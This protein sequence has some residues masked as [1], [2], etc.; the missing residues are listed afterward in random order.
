MAC[1]KIDFIYILDQ[2]R[3]FASV[4]LTNYKRY[5]VKF[6]YEIIHICTAVVDE[7]EE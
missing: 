2:A 6:L 5:K 4:C 3:R 7:S 1:R